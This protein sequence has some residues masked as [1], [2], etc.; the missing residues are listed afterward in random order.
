MGDLNRGIPRVT[1]TT[2]N[3]PGPA[4]PSRWRGGR[5]VAVIVS[6]AVVGVVLLLVVFVAIPLEPRSITFSLKDSC[7]TGELADNCS[8]FVGFVS[9][10][11]S[12]VTVSWG[13]NA[14][15]SPFPYLAVCT[16]P[17]QSVFLSVDPVGAYHFTS[18]G[19]RTYCAF[20]GIEGAST[21]V[22]VQ[23]ESPVL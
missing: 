11:N 7:P 20:G 15:D 23:V 13:T 9:L 8:E 4:P 21:N 18:S 17:D 3:K 19:G 2:A 22:T 12:R 5:R 16:L 1:S 6:V 14:S 10:W